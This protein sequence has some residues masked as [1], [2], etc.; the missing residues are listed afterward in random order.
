ML[1]NLSET[2][3]CCFGTVVFECVEENLVEVWYLL[4]LS[5]WKA[6]LLLRLVDFL[7]FPELWAL[8]VLTL[9]MHM[10]VIGYGTT[11]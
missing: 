10:I 3:V 5:H 8:I 7:M 1:E 9:L 2:M 6:R 4:G 11:S